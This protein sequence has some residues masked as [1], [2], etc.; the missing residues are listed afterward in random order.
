M[1]IIDFK[2]QQIKE[3]FKNDVLDF[4]DF[5]DEEIATYFKKRKDANRLLDFSSF[6]SDKL[7]QELKD[8]LYLLM[9]G[10]TENTY[11]SHVST[12]FFKFFVYAKDL[13][14]NSLFDEKE[15]IARQKYVDYRHID[16]VVPG[17]LI[18]A[19]YSS[20]L[21]YYDTRV[22][23]DRDVWDLKLFMIPESRLNLSAKLFSLNF[24]P[25]ESIE[26]R[27][28]IKKY[29]KYLIGSTNLV[30]RTINSILNNLTT[31][32]NT[33]PK[34][35]ME[36]D[37]EDWIKYQEWLK[38]TDR[39]T[40]TCYKFMLSAQNFYTFLIAREIYKDKHPLKQI[41]FNVPKNNYIE[42]SLSDYVILQLFN[43]LH[44]LPF[45]AMV[46]F[47]INFATGMRISDICQLK[48]DCLYIAKE[49]YFIKHYVQKMKKYQ[50][51]IIPKSVYDL[52]QKQITIVKSKG[53]TYMFPISDQQDIPRNTRYYRE[54]I[55]K[56]IESW[57]IKNED[58]TPY[59][60]KSHEFRHTI[61]TTLLNDYNVDL[62]VI[63]LGVLGHSEINMSLCYAER[64][65]K[66][67]SKYQKN[68]IGIDGNTNSSNNLDD[69]FLK[70][71]DWMNHTTEMQVLPDGLCS[72][73]MRLGTCP[74]FEACLSCEYFR[75]GIEH[76]EIHKKH[77]AAIENKIPLY[78][79]NGWIQNLETAKAQRDSLKKI[80]STLEKL[81]EEEENGSSESI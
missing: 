19:L 22:G 69:K 51:N 29:A 60:Y 72:Y 21:D 1:E 23:T 47:V 6:S 32:S 65:D 67:N 7:K 28:L 46:L 24:L 10:K 3:F 54:K 74:N 64:S 75:T 68:Y 71:V 49:H 61:A 79:A 55:N 8:Y 81:K 27:E 45:D 12:E 53:H 41:M 70:V 26:D 17:R 78:E 56:Y 59:R 25:I 63:Q 2:E 36:M 48:T 73:P 14:L 77:L 50:L 18:H 58:G 9:T 34:T 44:L 30:I 16:D 20:L 52:M 11:R 37:E 13:N 42:T 31:V 40:P 5:P 57:N 15:S 33:I 38:E 80:I 66:R 76:L 4:A 62:S 35:F 43:H 39:T